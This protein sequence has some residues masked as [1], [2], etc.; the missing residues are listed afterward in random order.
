MPNPLTTAC[1]Q[2]MLDYFWGEKRDVHR[3]CGY[4]EWAK[5]HPEESAHLEGLIKAIAVTERD[6]SEY[7]NNLPVLED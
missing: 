6:V 5:A 3:W 4:E 7:I 1:Q 2:R